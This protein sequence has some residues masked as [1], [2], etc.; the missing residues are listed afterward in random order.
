MCFIAGS[1]IPQINF[2]FPRGWSVPH[3]KKNHGDKSAILY[4]GR[5]L[6]CRHVIAPYIY[7]IRESECRATS[8][9]CRRVSSARE[10][11]EE[12][13]VYRRTLSQ[14]SPPRRGGNGPRSS[15]YSKRG[16]FYSSLPNRHGSSRDGD[17]EKVRKAARRKR[18]RRGIAREGGGG[19][20]RVLGIREPLSYRN[21]VARSQPFNELGQL[22]L[23]AQSFPAFRFYVNFN[24]LRR[25]CSR[26]SVFIDESRAHTA[27]EH[28]A[29]FIHDHRIGIDE[30]SSSHPPSPSPCSFRPIVRIVIPFKRFPTSV[31]PDSILPR[32]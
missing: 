8:T 21:G 20:E 9:V 24:S 5:S 23:Y 14:L 12:L 27:A 2:P 30:I 31:T 15:N 32:R 22:T 11:L 4:S 1:Q 25:T 7:E 10:S 18:C 26:K 19:K 6:S 17:L 13:L 28:S 3:V 29:K 16:L